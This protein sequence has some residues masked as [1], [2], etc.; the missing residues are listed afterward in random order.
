M[1]CWW[2]GRGES[3]NSDHTAIRHTPGRLYWRLAAIFLALFIVIAGILI[4]FTD[5][6]VPLA[7]SFTT[8]LSVVA[9]WMLAKKYVE[10]W[11]VWIVIDVVS[12]GLYVF[13]DL[14]FTSALYALYAVIAFFGYRKWL[15]QIIKS[16]K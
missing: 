2:G 4:M 8:A 11:L 9:M 1:A 5:S 6:N 13:K 15:N 12:V 7:D 10:Q 16:N 14:P 3:G